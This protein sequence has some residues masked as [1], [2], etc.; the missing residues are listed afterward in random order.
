MVWMVRSRLLRPRKS[1][2]DVHDDWNLFVIGALNV[3]QLA[4]WGGLLPGAIAVKALYAADALYLMADTCWVC[5]RPPPA[6]MSGG[7]GCKLGLSMRVLSPPPSSQPRGPPT[8]CNRQLV[9]VPTCVPAQARRGLLMHHIIVC[10][11]LPIAAGKPVLM[12]HL[13][14]TWVVELQSWTHIAA[15]RLEA[16]LA[17]HLERVNLPCV[18]PGPDPPA[19]SMRGIL[20]IADGRALRA[21]LALS[22][23]G[24]QALLCNAHRRLSAH[25]VGLRAEPR[26]SARGAA[27]RPSAGVGACAAQ[28][29]PLCAIW[30]DAELGVQDGDTPFVTTERVSSR[31]MWQLR[32]L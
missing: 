28:P 18:S 17:Q 6:S 13:L 10:C 27:P 11:C 26:C 29:T 32:S 15:R 19:C 1:M 20:P 12:A 30:A 23:Y 4:Y 2:L 5:R 9:F 24:Y 25:L 21:S 14:R 16:P 3:A 8:R 7:I 31:F 22:A